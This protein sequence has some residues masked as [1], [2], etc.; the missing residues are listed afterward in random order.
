MILAGT[1]RLLS[2]IYALIAHIVISAH[3][4]D[5][6]QMDSFSLMQVN[7]QLDGL[8]MGGLPRHPKPSAQWDIVPWSVE[9]CASLDKDP[10]A[11]LLKSAGSLPLFRRP[12]NSLSS[13]V[14]TLQ[15]QQV[16][17]ATA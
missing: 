1:N 4:G 11:A 10:R 5:D 16:S 6:T 17:R 2:S 3:S 7:L 12:A 13:M 9:P 15:V 8:G 14:S